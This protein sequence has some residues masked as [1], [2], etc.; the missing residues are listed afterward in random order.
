MVELGLGEG[1]APELLQF[2][3]G[4]VFY[5]ASSSREQNA[6]FACQ[7]RTAS[8]RLPDTEGAILKFFV[9]KPHE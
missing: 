3:D 7:P 4:A 9:P 6:S 8:K 2:R 5:G 1:E